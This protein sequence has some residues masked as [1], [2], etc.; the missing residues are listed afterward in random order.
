MRRLLN[1]KRSA[2]RPAAPS[3][4]CPGGAYVGINDARCRILTVSRDGGGGFVIDSGA[5]AEDRP[6]CVPAP[7]LLDFAAALIRLATHD[8]DRAIHDAA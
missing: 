8:E 6:L 3:V 7:I 1:P 4:A 2:D 5:I